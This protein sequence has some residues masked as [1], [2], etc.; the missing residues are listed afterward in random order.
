MENEGSLN[1]KMRKKL[2]KEKRK[3]SVKK[4]NF[5]GSIDSKFAND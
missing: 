1:P 4:Q 5:R 2:I 3:Q